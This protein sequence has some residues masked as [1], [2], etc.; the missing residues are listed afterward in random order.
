MTR[1]LV[2]G[3][4]LVEIMAT[5]PG[6][7]FREALDLRGPFPSG[8]PAIFADQLARQ[9]LATALVSC[10]GNDD[11]GRLNLDRLREAGVDVGAIRIHPAAVTGS[12]FVRYRPEGGRDFVF[13]IADSACGRIE[14]DAASDAVVEAATHLHVMGS[15]LSTP[16]LVELVLD[17]ARRIKGKG[18]TV[19]FDPNIRPEIL[20]HG[21]M[22]ATLGRVLAMTDLFLPSEGEA[23]MF[24]GT[25]RDT[26]ALPVLFGQGIRCIVL[27]LGA[28]GSRYV[29]PEEDVSVPGFAVEE[30][31]PT[32]AG[33]TF[34][35]TFLAGWLRGLP[36][37]EALRRANAAG[38]LA[39]TR[40]GPMEG[41]SAPASIDAFLEMQSRRAP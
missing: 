13:N 36:A 30:V 1:V 18:G 17:A 41:A 19:S 5:T 20:G 14:R 33:D 39:V 27:K 16:A 22:R 29:S 7:G 8:A 31:D 40:L 34:G 28:Q 2:I 21:D 37:R 4:I 9:G 24:A 38:A 10:V 3:E 11:F 12:A 23:A 6:H 25:A 15:S 26:E 35:A 32:G